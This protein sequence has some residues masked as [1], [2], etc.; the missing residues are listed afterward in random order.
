L[1]GYGQ[2]YNNGYSRT[3]GYNRNYGQ[4]SGSGANGYCGGSYGG[5]N[6]LRRKQAA[7]PS[8]SR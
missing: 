1:P 4:H 2:R 5:Y 6:P 7:D 8:S 3:T